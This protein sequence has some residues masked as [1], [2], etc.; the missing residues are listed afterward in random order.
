MSLATAALDFDNQVMR[1]G[2]KM[3]R[4]GKVVFILVLSAFLSACFHTKATVTPHKTNVPRGA[5]V[6]DV[7]GKWVADFSV[8]GATP[9]RFIYQVQ[10][11]RT[12]TEVYADGTTNGPA[13]RAW[14]G[15]HNIGWALVSS[16]S[17]ISNTD[18]VTNMAGQAG[19]TISATGV[20]SGALTLTVPLPQTSVLTDRTVF[21]VDSNG[22]TVAR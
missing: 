16:A 13:L 5:T 4:I 12:G 20:G 7:Y 14:D 21:E 9:A 11:V 15:R 10:Y 6:V 8:V 19:A 2:S 17:N 3:I 18:G 22:I 1:G